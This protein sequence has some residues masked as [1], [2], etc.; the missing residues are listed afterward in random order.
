VG[1]N[2]DAL[3]A[4]LQEEGTEEFA[5]SRGELTGVI[6]SKSMAIAKVG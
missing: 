5:K 3:A 1:V 6:D 2:V 4:H